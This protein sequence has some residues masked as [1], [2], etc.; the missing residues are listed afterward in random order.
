M[1]VAALAESLFEFR[2]CDALPKEL[3][4]VHE[5]IEVGECRPPRIEFAELA[6][7]EEGV[8]ERRNY[9]PVVSTRM[10]LLTSTGTDTKR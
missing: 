1:A 7:Q 3:A 2:F 5:D 8:F 4:K 9:N 6:L 10:Q